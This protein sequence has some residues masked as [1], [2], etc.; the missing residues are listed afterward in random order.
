MTHRH[1]ATLIAFALLQVPAGGRLF[2]QTPATFNEHTLTNLTY[3]NVGPFRMGA[4]VSMV[5]VPDGKDHLYTWY[6]GFWTGGLWK[7]IN[8]GTTFEP[9]FDGHAKLSIGTVATAPSNPDIVW[10]GTGDAFTSRRDS[11]SFSVRRSTFPAYDAPPRIAG[12]SCP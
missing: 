4:R 1:A 3:R 2:A 11:S 9:V 7:T 8:N 6:V 5:A 12:S 10:V